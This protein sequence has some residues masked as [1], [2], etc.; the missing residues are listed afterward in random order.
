[1]QKPG[2]KIKLEVW[3]EGR[4]LELN[5]TLAESKD[6]VVA[7][8]ASGMGAHA[9]LGVAVRPLTPDERSDNKLSS[10]LVVEQAAGAAARAGIQPGDVIVSVNGS[11]VKTA[12]QLQE[13]VA[14]ENKHL[15]V[16]IQRGNGRI[17]IP[18]RFG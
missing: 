9:K 2:A 17:F 16:L 4:T 6:A 18:V 7:S 12:E 10:G 15:A 3:R 13:I 5:A 14:K 1:M 11:S 8:E